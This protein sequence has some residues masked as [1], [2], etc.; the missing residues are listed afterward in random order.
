MGD[1]CDVNP[2]TGAVFEPKMAQTA[3]LDWGLRIAMGEFSYFTDVCLFSISKFSSVK[4]DPAAK[5]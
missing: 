5:F 4:D 1:I 2:S 3:L